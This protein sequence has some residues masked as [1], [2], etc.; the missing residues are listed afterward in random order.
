[1]NNTLFWNNLYS[2]YV[3][4]LKFNI[5]FKIYLMPMSPLFVLINTNS[6]SKNIKSNANTF[7]VNF[8]L[9]FIIIY[10]FNYLFI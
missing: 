8:I 5:T 10:L 1:M 6:H 3:F 9:F 7:S 4:P 2:Q